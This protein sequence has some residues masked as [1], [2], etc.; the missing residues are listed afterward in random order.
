M[1]LSRIAKISLALQ[2]LAE[3]M[4]WFFSSRRSRKLLT[5]REAIRLTV[6]RRPLDPHVVKS[7][8]M[9]QSGGRQVSV[10]WLYLDAANAICSDALGRPYGMRRNFSGMDDELTSVFGAEDVVVME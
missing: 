10:T 6:E 1:A 7:A 3:G 5:Y 9:R 4:H 8:L 2:A